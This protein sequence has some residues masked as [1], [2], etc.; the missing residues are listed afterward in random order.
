MTTKEKAAY[1]KGLADG[2]GMLDDSKSGRV[3]SCIIDILGELA[4]DVEDIEDSVFSLSE[5]VEQLG[6]DLD[7][8][9]D[10]LCG[11]DE[12]EDEE[13]RSCCSSCCCG[14][15]DEDEDEDGE[16]PV[17]Y[18]VTCPACGE[19]ITVDE[20]VLDLGSIPCPKCGENLEFDFDFDP[21]EDE[22]EDE[23]E[24]AD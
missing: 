11:E 21:D 2:L 3:L 1:L 18:E 15:E 24:N 17:F 4:S 23:G 5:E 9:G 13:L 22:A 20:D 14:G 6:V 10:I 8:V 19:T 16:E 7:E 12:D